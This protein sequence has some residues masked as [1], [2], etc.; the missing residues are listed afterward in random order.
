M[1]EV[2]SP[3]R[4]HFPPAHIEFVGALKFLDRYP[5]SLEFLA[6]AVQGASGIIFRDLFGK[7]VG[8]S[9]DGLYCSFL[10]H[11]S[12]L[13]QSCGGIMD[14]FHSAVKNYFAVASIELAQASRVADFR[15]SETGSPMARPRMLLLAIS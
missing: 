6:F 12:C 14:R 2:S 11:T 1:P 8:P 10:R 13:M 4:L 9:L 3:C 15:T 5:E 7:M